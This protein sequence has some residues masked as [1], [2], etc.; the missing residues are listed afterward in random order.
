[1]INLLG[2]FYG[3]KKIPQGKHL[4]HQVQKKKKQKQK[5]KQNKEQKPTMHF[6][7]LGPQHVKCK[8]EYINK[9]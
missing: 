9:R 7:Q 6:A 3:K 4:M 8:K 5:P 2:T 1:M